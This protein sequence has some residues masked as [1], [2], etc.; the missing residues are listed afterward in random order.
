MAMRYNPYKWHRIVEKQ[1][2]HWVQHKFGWDYKSVAGDP[3]QYN[4]EDEKA[5]SKF[6]TYAKGKH[7]EYKIIIVAEQHTHD[8]VVIRRKLKR[9]K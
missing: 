6:H 7:Y 9:H 1:V 3:Y 4:E 2:P 5:A 8:S